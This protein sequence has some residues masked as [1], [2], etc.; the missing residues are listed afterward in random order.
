ML[1][2]VGHAN[3]LLPITFYTSFTVTRSVIQFSELTFF[4]SKVH[5]VGTSQL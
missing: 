2:T 4:V 1:L 5:K 3:L